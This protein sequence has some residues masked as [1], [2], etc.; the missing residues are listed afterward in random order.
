MSMIGQL[1][2]SKAGHDKE[3]LYVIVAHKGDFVYLSDGRSRMPEAP[4]KKRVKHIQP[5]NEWVDGD[6]LARLQDGAA[7]RAEEIKYALKQYIR[8]S[9]RNQ[10]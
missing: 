6:L 7:V 5:I 3:A 2:T 9:M 1:A 4:K 10:E 8:K